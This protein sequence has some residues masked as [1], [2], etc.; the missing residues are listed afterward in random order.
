MKIIYL[1]ISIFVFIFSF[2]L[3]SY[4]LILNKNSNYRFQILNSKFNFFLIFLLILSLIVYTIFTFNLD[5]SNTSNFNIYNLFAVP[6]GLS[7]NAPQDPNRRWPAGVP[8]SMAIFGTMAATFG[9]LSQTPGISP[10][11]RI[12]TSLGAGG[13]TATNIAYHS[14]IENSIG[15]NRFMWSLNVSASTGKWPSIDETYAPKNATEEQVKGFIEKA[16]DKADQT[17]VNKSVSEVQN[18][19]NSKNGGN[20]NQFISSGDSS[21]ILFQLFDS[22]M[23]HLGFLFKPVSVNGYL[24]DLIGQQ[25]AIEFILL[26]TSF[27]MCLLFLAYLANNLLFF[28]KEY[29]INKFGK[30][31]KFILL[32]L[33]YQVFCIRFSLFYLPIFMFLGF[34]VLIHGSYFLITHQIPYESL[35][36]DLHTLIK[37]R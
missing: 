9:A 5:Y 29:I 22:F 15:F 28:N 7:S 4:N 37:P 32:Y 16:V 30:N 8:Q 25:I 18:L 27:F 36:V 24:D 2:S 11:L 26:L 10:R 13:I 23:Q 21:D 35:G 34:F 6:E 19:I 31:N 17:I 33:K 3:L 1:S 20:A 12:I 14:A